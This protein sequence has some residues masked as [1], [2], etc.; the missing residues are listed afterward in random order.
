MILVAGAGT[1][2]LSAALFLVHH[3][4]E[5]MVVERREGP[6]VHPR[7]TGVGPRTA[8]LFREAGIQDAVNA[9]AIE[10]TTGLGKITAPTL[11]SADLKALAAAA[12]PR[13]VQ[14]ANRFGAFSPAALRGICPQNRL[15]EVLLKAVLDRGVK[16]AY[17]T[18]LT[19]FT[20]DATG[21]TATLEAAGGEGASASDAAWRREGEPRHP[22]VAAWRREGAARQRESATLRRETA[23]RRPEDAARGP[24]DSA[25][26]P[27]DS[28]RRPEDAARGREGAARQHEDAALGR[29]DAALAALGREDA[30]LGREDAALGR[31]VVRAEY[32]VAADG[33]R[34]GVREAL[35]I[36]VSGPGAL[37]DALMNI[38]FEAD[39]SPYTRGHSFVN[40]GTDAGML[41]TIDGERTWVLHVRREDGMTG[42][43]CRELVRA[44]VGDD[45]LDV[46][47]I[48]A[49]P[50][51][52]RGQLA[53]RFRDGRV[54]LAGDAAHTVPP[55]GA[56]GMNTGVADAH[57]LAWKIAAVVDGTAGPG[58]L[59]TYEA[60]RR[61]VG[62]L[63]L[64]QSLVRLTDPRLHWGTGPEAAAAR[65]EAGAVNAPIVHLG[66][67]YDSSAITD[68]CTDLPSTEDLVLDGSPGSRVPHLW[69]EDG[70]STLDL[71]ASRFTV[72][73][74]TE[75]WVKAAESADLAAYRIEAEWLPENGMLLV[76]P[77]GFVAFRTS[78]PS[79]D[80]GKVMRRLLA[81]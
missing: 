2:G 75:E 7:A 24:V 48:G 21:V 49:Q 64:E 11:A 14:V 69:V 22:E 41:M 18:A 27:E 78:D 60:E 1:V 12:P 51:R 26:G 39:L 30:A 52:V 61:P 72:F 32:L 62:A 19:S 53:D 54:L 6:D 16:V 34:S 71:V 77:D 20:Q 13:P 28:A 43:R 29:E 23:A 38:L 4:M 70:V 45:G 74:N 8:E 47:V 36:G 25:R 37:G 79:T 59:D 76:R 9:A 81:S 46:N 65:A 31:E 17:S 73:T 5:V 55:L 56:F 80:L 40:C 58:L 50:W 63:A 67:R 10:M 33:A 57:N 42:A 35:G 68:A 15:D 44:A 66:Y 3:G